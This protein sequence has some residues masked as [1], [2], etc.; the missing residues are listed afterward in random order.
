LGVALMTIMANS[1]ILIGIPTYWQKVFT[2][3]II[4]IGTGVSAYQMN[5]SQRH[6]VSRRIAKASKG[7]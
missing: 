2:G 3:A 7:A 4:I 6:L 1:L 5:A